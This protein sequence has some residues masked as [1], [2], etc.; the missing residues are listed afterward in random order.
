MNQPITSATRKLMVALVVLVSVAAVG[1]GLA[2]RGDGDKLMLVARF[3]DASP[4]LV[5]NDVRTNGVRVG[6][7]ANI[8]GD[9]RE[10]V[11]TLELDREALPVHEDAKVSIRPVSLLGER[12]VDLDPGTPNKPALADRAEIPTSA[13]SQSVGLDE[14]LNTLDADTSQS[15]AMLV[16]ALGTGLDKNG[17]SVRDAI[18]A[19]APTTKRTAELSRILSAQNQTLG[20][21]VDSLEPVAAGL[22]ADNGAA[23]DGLVA[24][25]QRALAATAADEQAFR[26]LLAELPRTLR[27]ARSTLGVLEATA[28]DTTPTLRRLRPVTGDLDQISRELQAFAAAADPALRGANPVLEKAEHL[29][30]EARPVA[31][32]LRAQGPAL[33]SAATSARPLTAKLGGEFTTVMEFFKGWA[34]ATNG[35]DGLAHYFRAGLVLTPYSVTGLVPAGSGGAAGDKKPKSGGGGLL[36]GTLPDGLLSDT[37]DKLGGVTGLTSNQE[38]D[39]LGLLLGRN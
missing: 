24:S 39:A 20:S 37:T 35:R 10:A 3:D 2:N 30:R 6:T 13:T 1:V 38:L 29:L 33:K 4:L 5:G 25:S 21:L 14:V 12:F 17:V 34:L 31:A 22:A 8:T 23:L 9:G 7:I 32:A 19:L 27:T 11:V 28:D 16:T 15:L 18:K 26:A 36:G